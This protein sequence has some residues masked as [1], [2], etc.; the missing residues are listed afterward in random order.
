MLLPKYFL[1]FWTGSPRTQ[2][3]QDSRRGRPGWGPCSPASHSPQ[4][5]HGG[6]RTWSGGCRQEQCVLTQG[7]QP[8]AHEP[9]SAC[10]ASEH[11]TNALTSQGGD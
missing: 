1:R 7:L 4:E 9:L 2:A 8:G 11:L 5:A 6:D 3:A 10:G